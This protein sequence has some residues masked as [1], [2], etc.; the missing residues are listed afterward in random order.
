MT[1]DIFLRETKTGL[2]CLSFLGPK[3]WTKIC[4]STKNVKTTISFTNALKREMSN[5]LCK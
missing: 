5:I 1:L 2:Q 3:I 4:H